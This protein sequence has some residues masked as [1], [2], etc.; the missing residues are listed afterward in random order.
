MAMMHHGLL[1]HFTGQSHANPG[2]EYVIENWETVSETLAKAGLPLVFTGHFHAQDI[3]SKTW[4]SDGK[5]Y[6]LTDV[7]TGSLVTYPSPFRK[8]TRYLNDDIRIESQNITEVSYD[9]APLTFAEYAE[10]YLESGLYDLAYYSLVLPADQ[11]GYGIPAEQAQLI[12]PMIADAFKAHYAGNENPSAETL[13]A[14]SA[15]LGSSD[16]VTVLLGQ[17]LSSLWTDLK[18]DDREVVIGAD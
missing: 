1:E 12:A 8:V 2:S 11:G 15:F 10:D 16:P 6:T 9:T 13:T 18:P 14:V 3:T 4:E 7:E 5:S 17:T